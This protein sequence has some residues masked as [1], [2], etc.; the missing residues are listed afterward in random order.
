MTANVELRLR[1]PMD[2][3]RMVWQAAETLL[4]NMP[5]A[6]DPEGSRYN[7]LLSIQEILTNILRHGYQGDE[8]RPIHLQMEADMQEF[9]VSIRDQGPAF[10]PLQ[11]D[12]AAVEEQED[13]PLEAGGYGIYIAKMVMD[14][15]TYAREGDWNVLSM[16]KSVQMPVAQMSEGFQD[17]G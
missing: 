15:V 4:E 16:R 1:G 17:K 12:L 8:Q 2:H 10:N 7:A 6:D 5:F 11:H 3:L 9:K 13:M 14:E